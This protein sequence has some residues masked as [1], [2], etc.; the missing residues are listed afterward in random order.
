MIAL[1]HPTGNQNVRQVLQALDD[2]DLLHEFLTSVALF[3]G[4]LWDW[5]SK[6]GIG[7]ELKRRR[8][9][10]HLKRS[11]VQHPL[12][13]LGR[14]LALKFKL[15]SLTRHEEGSFCTD[16]VYWNQDQLFSK[17]IDKRLNKEIAGVYCYEDGALESFRAAKNHGIK[18]F[19]DLPIAYWKTAKKL[20]DEEIE[21][22][23]NWA[24]TLSGTNYSAK[25]RD[26]KVEEIALADVI[27]CPSR[28]VHDSIPGSIRHKVP[29][30]ITPFG[31]PMPRLSG[32][33]CHVS[34]TKK[35]KV[36]FVGSMTQRKGLADLF[37]A[38][39]I[40]GSDSFEL[41]VLGS[42]VRP[43]EFYKN[44]FSD[45]VYHAPRS[46]DQVL[47]LMKSCDVFVLPSLVEGRAL[48]QQ[49]ALACG[50]PII[51]TKNAGA[52]DLVEDGA[53]GFLV[54]IRDPDAI[55]EK[56][57]LIH[58][59]RD[60]LAAM[61]QAAVQKAASV[62]WESYRKSIASIVASTIGDTYHD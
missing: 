52:E 38:M 20:L 32:L 28:F 14:V 12:R 49:E 48:V 2:A 25:K 54:P 6:L 50:L 7:S 19:Y 60:C 27:L 34:D 42:A 36:L 15:G 43:L 61:K 41:N 53:A 22:W 29:V 8:F 3:D 31:S 39:K 30:H 44:E 62:T 46:H 57:E 59:N 4:N 9:D 10:E 35:L 51:V 16:R 47:K 18:C 13:E 11:T 58:T 33:D 24:P 1:S 55:A 37:E 17:R 21:R 40:L 23:P 5:A 26:R 45:F 56:L